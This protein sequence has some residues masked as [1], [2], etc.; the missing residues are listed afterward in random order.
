MRRRGAAPFTESFSA[1]QPSSHPNTAR[2]GTLIQCSRVGIL[3]RGAQT[4]RLRR[5]SPGEE[6]ECAAGDRSRPSDTP[7]GARLDRPGTRSERRAPA[8]LTSTARTLGQLPRTGNPCPWSGSQPKAPSTISGGSA[9]ASRNG[10]QGQ[11]ESASSK[12]STSG[13]RKKRFLHM[14]SSRGGLLP[15]PGA[16]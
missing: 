14:R 9:S 8:P 15:R 12:R 6:R 11:R 13:S 7:G 3:H 16:N 1:I 10:H 4:R 2:P 5:S